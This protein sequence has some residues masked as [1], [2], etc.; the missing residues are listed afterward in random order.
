MK[1]P[2]SL[3]ATLALVAVL[4][5]GSTTSSSA[6]NDENA[7]AYW[8]GIAQDRI[9]GPPLPPPS[10][11]LRPPA[12]STVLAAM[13]HGAMYDAVAAFDGALSPFVADLTHAP[14][15]SVEAAVAKA[16][17]DVLMARLPN[18]QQALVVSAY[19]AYITYLTD[20]L[21]IDPADITAGEVTG[22]AAAAAMLA[23]R[24]GDGFGASTSYTPLTAHI[25]GVF[26]PIAA[27]VV[28]PYASAPS[29]TPTPIDQMLASVRPFTFDNP[30]DY[31]P[32]AP[33]AIT[34]KRY[35]QDLAEVQAAGRSTNHTDLA[36]PKT[37]TARFYS[38]PTYRQYSRAMIRLVNERGLDLRE[39]ARLLGYTWW[40]SPTR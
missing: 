24:D 12:S 11:A 25:A 3:A 17:R 22:T 36:D 5:F 15:A 32:S 33:Y 27:G 19:T 7:V 18:H 13:V 20:E 9:S 29:A 8:S 6:I 39:S 10:T 1:L 38:D 34:S 4:V 26:E 37:D 16:A 30:S 14:D 35:T 31:R 28:T 2:I 40:L 21:D 23:F